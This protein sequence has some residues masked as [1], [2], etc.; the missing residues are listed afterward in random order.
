ML[1]TR[2]CESE[3]K[4]NI[5]RRVVKS[6]FLIAVF[7]LRQGLP[8]PTNNNTTTMMSSNNGSGPQ[9]QPTQPRVYDSFAHEIASLQRRRKNRTDNSNNNAYK[10]T[11]P[12]GGDGS[13]TLASSSLLCCCHACGLDCSVV[14]PSERMICPKCQLAH[15]CS[16]HCMRWDWNSGGHAQECSQLPMPQRLE[17]LNY[18]APA[19]TVQNRQ[20]ERLAAQQQGRRSSNGHNNNMGVCCRACGMECA[21]VNAEKRTT[22]PHCRQTEYCSLDCFEWD[23]EKG[24]HAQVCLGGPKNR[25]ATAKSPST[26][27]PP[28]TSSLSQ[29]QR[30]ELQQTLMNQQQQHLRRMQRDP[31]GNITVNE[32]T[33]RTVVTEY[34]EVTI[35]D[36]VEDEDD[37]ISQDPPEHSYHTS[38]VNSQ[39]LLTSRSGHESRDDK[40]ED[41]G[42]TYYNE[43]HF[44]DDPI[45]EDDH[46]DKN[47]PYYLI[48]NHH[49]PPG[50]SSKEE[51]EGFLGEDAPE[52]VQDDGHHYDNYD[53][54]DDKNMVVIGIDSQWQQ[55]EDASS[56]G[57]DTFQI[58]QYGSAVAALNAPYRPRTAADAAAPLSKS[59]SQRSRPTQSITMVDPPAP[60]KLNVHASS[61]MMMNGYSNH[62][63]S[64]APGQSLQDS[65]QLAH[66]RNLSNTTSETLVTSNQNLGSPPNDSS[67]R[68]ENIIEAPRGIMRP[69]QQQPQPQQPYSSQRPPNN[70]DDMNHYNHRPGESRSPARYPDKSASP[71]PNNN[72]NN[73]NNN[74]YRPTQYPPRPHQEQALLV[75]PPAPPAARRQQQQQQLEQQQQLQLQQQQQYQARGTPQNPSGADPAAHISMRASNNNNNGN[76]N[77]M[78]DSNSNAATNGNN[79][80]IAMHLVVDQRDE[81]Q[82]DMEIATSAQQQEEAASLVSSKTGSRRYNKKRVTISCAILMSFAIGIVMA[83]VAVSG[84]VWFVPFLTGDDNE[85]D[86][87]TRDAPS[88]PSVAPSSSSASSLPPVEMVVESEFPMPS[89]GSTTTTSVALSDSLLVVGSFDGTVTTYKLDDNRSGQ[90]T[91][92]QQM[93]DFAFCADLDLI[94]DDDGDVYLVVGAPEHAGDRG[95]VFVYSYQTSYNGWEELGVSLAGITSQNN[96]L[97][98]RRA[99]NTRSLLDDQ[100]GMSVAMSAGSNTNNYRRRLVVGAPEYSV[101]ADIPNSG[102]VTVYHFGKNS[103]NYELMT[104]NRFPLRGESAG[105]R[106]GSAVDITNDGATIG[107]GEPGQQKFHLYEWDGT[108]WTEVLQLH[109]PEEKDLGVSV[110]FLDD[111]SVAV[112]APSAENNKGSVRVCRKDG[113]QWAEV[114]RMVGAKEGDRLGRVGTLAGSAGAEGHKLFAI[115]GSQKLHRYDFATSSGQWTERFEVDLAEI[116]TSVAV[117]PVSGKGYKVLV[118]FEGQNSAATLYS[119]KIIAPTESTPKPTAPQLDPQPQPSLAPQPSSPV[120]QPSPVSSAVP[121]IAPVPVANGS[122]TEA[123]ARAPVVTGP[124]ANP[125]TPS[126][127]S[128]QTPQPNTG[129]PTTTAE[130]QLIGNPVTSINANGG[131]GGAVA[132]VDNMVVA[133]EPLVSNGGQ[134]H[135]YRRDESKNRWNNLETVLDLEAL[136]FGSAVDLTN[137]SGTISLLVGAK[138]TRDVNG[139]VSFG[140]AHYYEYNGSSLV[141]IGSTMKPFSLVEAGGDFGASVAMASTLRRFAVG[142]PSS[143]TFEKKDTGRVY[144]YEYVGTDWQKMT[145]EPLFG[146]AGSMLGSSLDMSRD[147]SRVFAGAPTDQNGNG[148]VFYYAWNATNSAWKSLFSLGGA[149][150]EA[151]GT[152]VAVLDDSGSLIAFGGPSYGD[153]QGVIRVYSESGAEFFTKQGSDIVGATNEWI[154]TTLCGAQG[155]LAYGTDTGFF[156]VYEYSNGDWVEVATGPTLGS[157]VVSIA[158]SEDGNSVVVGLANEEVRV[159]KLM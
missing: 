31:Y 45:D 69:G 80:N 72:N 15:Y 63:G 14:L 95:A 19:H 124:G 92:V 152:S 65:I 21:L 51:E 133:T 11:N 59:L 127:S 73:N 154:G 144:T 60:A 25:A 114:E 40:E 37:H 30:L 98:R 9:Q 68:L 62:T 147:G 44:E 93:D 138:E 84:V 22:C 120:S 106:F 52:Q 102:Q 97:R 16:A 46:A 7:S 64:S 117:S 20:Q 82:Q 143:S 32:T 49:D 66:L 130:W 96:S 151:L 77:R 87:D 36:D 71:K 111:N 78:L 81:E 12:D 137:V 58:N 99:A 4:E 142:A 10:T 38:H 103:T 141:Q 88:T 42:D 123:P 116:G 79:N 55:T 155:R 134:A 2:Q 140:S 74:S 90:W 29:K 57:M 115:A 75:V 27:A 104:E 33:D 91:V 148:A 28:P 136:E 159:Y 149:T 13:S 139:D 83:V 156:H 128:A 61:N 53:T 1:I 157:A 121:T 86:S 85:G 126:P 8:P 101:N 23:W 135:L 146:D 56:L 125:P 17:L 47:D 131:Y 119:E 6:S 105:G 107:V 70:H 109:Y 76:G 158:M 18:Q 145:A 39:T 100:F 3:Q 54:D 48:H 122:P 110:V 35:E 26:A 41:Y 132:I 24:G 118:G 153:N 5:E 94:K 129:A 113:N 67:K 34:T 89:T 150:K 112:G 50:V 43:E 108:K